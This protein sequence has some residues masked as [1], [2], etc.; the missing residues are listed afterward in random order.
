MSG[1]VYIASP[2]AGDVE[3][4]IEFAKAACRHAMRKG[5]T[6]IA[7]HLLYPQFLSDS[8]PSEREAGLRMGHRVLEA[9]N[10]LLVCGDRISEGMA[11]EIAEAKRLGIPIR[12]VSTQEI[13]GG[14]FIEQQDFITEKLYSPVFCKLEDVENMEQYD[15]DYWRDEIPQT[16][17]A[18][19]VDVIRDELEKMQHDDDTERGLMA[20]FDKDAALESKV[21]SLFVDV[22]VREDKLWGVATIT[23]TEP[24][25]QRELTILKDYLEGQYADGL[26][27]SFEQR[28]IKTGD[29]ELYVSLWENDRTY[30]IAT[31]RE[32]CERL[33][34][35]PPI[36]QRPIDKK[37]SVLAQLREAKSVPAAPPHKKSEP[38][39]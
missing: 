7:V 30:F 2:Y 15:G 24:L 8:D 1:L 26:G 34:L 22:E 25:N 29:G 37:P 28:P 36:P 4:N 32:F 17:A 9:C 23:L 35:E 18:F 11:L 31:E 14:I 12:E 21:R 39:R 6:P 10:S 38:E 16:Q 20:Y 3:R 5:L 33:G 19:Y 13:E 27:E